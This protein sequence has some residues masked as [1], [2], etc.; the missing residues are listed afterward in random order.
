MTP[1][2]EI[3]VHI[4]GPSRGA[5]DA[6]YRREAL[7]F[8]QFDDIAE[9]HT[10]LGQ[11]PSAPNTAERAQSQSTTANAEEPLSKTLFWGQEASTGTSSWARQN[12]N[13]SR[14]PDW[15]D[16]SR[17]SET[18]I[19]S[20]FIASTFPSTEVKQTP[21]LL[22]ERTPALPRPRTAPTPSTPAQARPLRRW[23]SDSFQTPPS[24]IPDSQ[25]SPPSPGL[26]EISSPPYLKHPLDSSSPSPTRH[27]SPPS[28][29]RPRLQIPSSPLPAAH[30]FNPRP[31]LSIPSSR[32]PRAT[33]PHKNPPS[34]PPPSH[35]PNTHPP[36]PTTTTPLEIHP[37]R[38]KPSTDAFT[39]H[40]TKSLAQI[41]HI[42]PLDE[43]FTPV[44]RTR[45]PGILERGHWL[46][47]VGGWE[48]E[49]KV[50]FWKGLREFVG[51]GSAGWGTW[52][53]WEIGG[54]EGDGGGVGLG[55]RE[56]DGAG[57]DDEVECG[58]KRGSEVIKIYCW[59]EVVGEVWLVLFIF[60]KRKIKH[61]GVKWVDASGEAVK[62]KK[63]RFPDVAPT[64]FSDDDDDDDD[65]DA[66]RSYNAPACFENAN[67]SNAT[68]V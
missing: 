46:I 3:L 17:P 43:Y 11:N 47:P 36:R 52:C 14:L 32:Q 13:Q 6:R 38:P 57:E 33:P 21:H 4:S 12:D 68:Q 42:L 67:L 40:R 56:G 58:K 1:P 44:T 27:A 9:R 30:P 16:R 66:S 35:I 31:R 53:V 49:W 63:E 10:L 55:D 24:E 8:L 50:H 61:S 39:T 64:P 5:D 51:K 19:S 28:A 23:Q 34:S 22:V 54:E 29:K 41:E 2:I 20:K 26:P 7:G 60:S 25:P 15:L 37:P 62:K 18:P 65:D 45:T 48:E 59:G